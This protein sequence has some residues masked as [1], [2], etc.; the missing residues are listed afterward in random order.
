MAELSPVMSLLSP[1]ESFREFRDNG[2]RL[3]GPHVGLESIHD[4]EPGGHHPV[5]IGD[6]LNGRYK[7]MDKLGNGG[8]A[9]VWLCRDV[10]R[11]ISQY[12]AIKILMAAA[13]IDDSPELRV[14]KL[15]RQG[16][17]KGE[18]AEHLCLPLGRFDIHGPNGHHFALVY[19]VLGPRVSRL[20]HVLNKDHPA[21]ELR[22][23]CFQVVRAMATLHSHGICHGDFRPANILTRIKGL[24]GLSED[25]IRQVFGPPKTVAVIQSSSEGGGSWPSTAP[26]YLVRPIEWE[27][28]D[29]GGGIGINFVTS[30]ACVVDF[31][32]SFDVRDLPED[33]GIP[34]EYCAPEY[35][36]DKRLGIGSDIW[37]L[38]CTLF[39]IRTGR[40]LF[41]IP[42]D[43]PDEH[44]KRMV[45]LLGKFPEPWWSTTWEARRRCFGE[46][47]EGVSGRGKQSARLLGGISLTRKR[48]T[49]SIE[50]V[51]ADGLV[52]DFGHNN[53]KSEH[54]AIAKDE[55]SL[56]ADLLRRIFKYSP[57][58][59]T[60]P[61]DILE[62]VWFG[63]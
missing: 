20:P 10:Q 48:T 59:R 51:L 6:V 31:A 36:L 52:Y 42:D 63:V 39:E 32:E 25:Q 3:D 13:S 47:Q 11:E 27:S 34:Q 49:H 24:G 30:R 56:F 60:P 43:D 54:R 55:I 21:K 12:F 44:L 61:E 33:L 45:N 15:L 29:F 23:I 7:V 22:D 46:D 53:K 2:L 50:D 37:A 9:N 4:Y 14:Y 58:Q 35:V 57:D 16:L 26:T 40:R 5:H 62:H 41:D 18:A 17:A 28:L 1:Q 38:G 19:P 8:R